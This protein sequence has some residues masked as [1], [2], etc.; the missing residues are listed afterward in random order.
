VAGVAL[1]VRVR[2]RTTFRETIDAQT[3]QVEV[4]A[5]VG[6]SPQRLNQLMTGRGV[7][8]INVLVAAAIER[9]L[10]VPPG[11]LFLA[12]AA[13]ADEVAVIGP[14]LQARDGD[15]PDAPIHEPDD[16]VYVEP[17]TTRVA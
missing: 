2:N 3:T 9:V 12:E 7:I 14:Y 11:Q 13:V 17:A 5:A 6:I 10:H 8:R 4:A 16:G 15:D 1:C